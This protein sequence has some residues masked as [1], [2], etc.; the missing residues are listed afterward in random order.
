MH[1]A[2]EKAGQTNAPTASP[3][4]FRRS[5]LLDHGRRSGIRRRPRAR[6]DL[7]EAG[8]LIGCNE[9]TPPEGMGGVFG[10]SAETDDQKL[11]PKRRSR[12]LEGTIRPRAESDK[13][14]FL[15][16]AMQPETGSAPGKKKGSTHA[17]WSLRI[18]PKPKSKV[19][20]DERGRRIRHLPDG[21]S[22]RE[23]SSAPVRCRTTWAEG[24]GNGP[25]R[26]RRPV[27]APGHVPQQ[28]GKPHVS[29][30]C[31]ARKGQRY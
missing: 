8:R 9:K 5:L 1:L 18:G 20:A 3:Q 10:S 14:R 28:C 25:S 17:E 4:N 19:M 7:R 2:P 27:Y 24:G 13:C 12:W 29:Y 16:A 6:N 21:H 23:E 26:P 22:L 31:H 15:R 30:A 11:R